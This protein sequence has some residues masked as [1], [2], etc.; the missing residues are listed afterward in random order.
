MDVETKREARSERRRW[1][2]VGE[3]HQDEDDPICG[4]AHG[5]VISHSLRVRRMLVCSEC[6]Q[7][8][9][10]KERFDEHSCHSAY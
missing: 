7:G 5:D 10:T 6:E 9:F 8:Y 2:P 4:W 3:T 1:C